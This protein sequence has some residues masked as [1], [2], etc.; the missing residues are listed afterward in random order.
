M[1]MVAVPLLVIGTGGLIIYYT[2]GSSRTAVSKIT[3]DLFREVSGRALEQTSSSVEQAIPSIQLL[4]RT[5]AQ[6]LEDKDWKA[7]AR[8]LVH[9][10]ANNPEF[11]WVTENRADRST[12]AAYRTSDKSGKT[13][14][15]VNH[16]S[17]DSTGRTERYEYN[18]TES[19]QWEE[20]VHDFDSEYDPTARPFWSAAEESRKRVWPPPYIF[21]ETGVPG[22]T[23]ALPR[24]NAD[25]KLKAVLT[26][27]FDLNS[28]SQIVSQVGLSENARIVLFTHDQV[29]LA[30]TNLRVVQKTGMKGEGKLLTSDSLSQPVLQRFFE[31]VKQQGEKEKSKSVVGQYQTQLAYDYQGERWLGSYT[32]TNL[33]NGLH[34]V[35]GVMAPESD[36]M[37]AVQRG[38]YRA[39]FVTMI[40]LACAMII[41]FVI[42][43]LA[44]RHIGWLVGELKEVGEFQLETKS[45]FPTIFHEVA[46][47]DRSLQTMKGGL[48]SFAR[49]VPKELVRT[50]L[51]SGQEARI[52]GSMRQLTVF[53]SD[54]ERFT[55]LAETTEPQ[56][57]AN[58][59]SDYL[60][61]MT[62]LIL[63]NGGTIDKYIGDSIM[64]F[65][66]APLDNPNHAAD[67]CK[68]AVLCQRR[69]QQLAEQDPDG[70]YSRLHT[71]IGLATGHAMVGNIGTSE[72]LNYTAIGDTVNIASRLEGLNKIYGTHILVAEPTWQAVGD[73]LIGRPVDKV[74]VKG[75]GGGIRVFELLGLSGQ[76]DENMSDVAELTRRAF[77]TFLNRNFTEAESLYQQV[78]ERLP[79]DKVAQ[80]MLARARAFI[81]QPPPDDWTGIHE[82][83]I[84]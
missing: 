25:G 28:L 34:W 35:I 22:I 66:G 2:T 52:D 31:V 43:R 45:E 19:G 39:L 9:I 70:P 14:L 27:D 29:L 37:G 81:E 47:V 72:R 61:E 46:E 80:H 7:R 53:F 65:W 17:I 84:K 64:A 75:R 30:E 6:G 38:F 71:R 68:T 83:S 20:H 59:I 63:E 3:G 44:S 79:D 54:I 8:H 58:L 69:L 13:V 56:A 10:I 11:T 5:L 21:Y 1:V 24:Y 15:R 62:D 67:A 51:A 60:Q 57:L 55:N 78:L 42:A 26:I 41:A 40:G 33:D 77:D 73:T 74:A 50:L 49:Y 32:S 4:D 48:R 12:T 36:F 23:C 16:S 82:I 76:T 18:V